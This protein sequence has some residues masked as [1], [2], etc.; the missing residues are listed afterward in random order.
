[1]DNLVKQDVEYIELLIFLNINN[2]IVL[3]KGINS[4]LFLM[5]NFLIEVQ[6]FWFDDFDFFEFKVSLCS[7][8]MILEVWQLYKN[9]MLYNDEDVREFLLVIIMVW[10]R[11]ILV[12]QIIL[13]G[14]FRNGGG[15]ESIKEFRRFRWIQECWWNRIDLRIL[16]CWWDKIYQR[17]WQCWWIQK[18]LQI[19]VNGFRNNWIILDMMMG[20]KI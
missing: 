11:R 9:K 18:I 8:R 16:M 20:Q 1:M 3:E 13:T 5:D 2:V 17:I 10:Y 19:Y 7:L 4:I 12:D 15:L 6:L 14:G